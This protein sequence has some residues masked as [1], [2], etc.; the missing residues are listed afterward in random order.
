MPLS[1][2]CS[3]VYSG[4]D[5]ETTQMFIDVGTDEGEMV[6][7]YIQPVNQAIHSKIQT[8]LESVI[9]SEISQTEKEKRHMTSLVCENQKE[10]IQ[11]NLLRIQK[12]THRLR[13]QTHGCR[14]EGIVEDFEKLMYTLLYLKWITNKNLLYSTWNSA[15]CYVPTWMGGGFGE[16]QIHVYVQLNSFTVH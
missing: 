10:I 5:M 2:H 13:K 14:G 7:I 6:Y 16:E 11:M 3:T 12:E 15:Q 1:V 8:D 4:Q 9:W